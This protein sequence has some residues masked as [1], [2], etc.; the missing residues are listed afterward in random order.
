M[1]GRPLLFL[2]SSSFLLET[3]TALKREEEEEE[4]EEAL[5][6]DRKICEGV[7][8]LLLFSRNSEGRFSFRC[9]V[10]NRN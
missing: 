6:P 10:R 7:R 2:L 4:E 3:D 9:L 8:L 5:S 1:E